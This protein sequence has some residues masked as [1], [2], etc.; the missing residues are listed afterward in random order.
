M[1]LTQ[2]MHSSRRLKDTLTEKRLQYK[3]DL[4]RSRV[5]LAA[6]YKSK[7]TLTGSA[8]QLEVELGPK[9]DSGSNQQ[10]LLQE[11]SREEVKSLHR[12]SKC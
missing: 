7:Q 11:S 3:L 4:N 12:N 2:W 1:K 5:P 6:A 10:K 8:L 9:P